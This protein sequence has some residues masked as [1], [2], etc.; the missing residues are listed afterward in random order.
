MSEMRIEIRNGKRVKITTDR[1]SDGRVTELVMPLDDGSIRN[2]P[3]DGGD[4]FHNQVDPSDVQ[5]VKDV[6]LLSDA[7]AGTGGQGTRE[8]HNMDPDGEGVPLL[9]DAI[10]N[11]RKQTADKTVTTTTNE[12]DGL[13]P[14]LSD[15][16][17]NQRNRR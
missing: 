5:D 17:E 7:L 10:E 13:P 3:Q 14:L 2:T 8:I 1:S 16:I 4:R 6:P 11:Q 9:S 15:A 12:D